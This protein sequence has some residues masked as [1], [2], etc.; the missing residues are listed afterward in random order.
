MARDCLC[1]RQHYGYILCVRWPRKQGISA[2][3]TVKSPVRITASRPRPILPAPEVFILKGNHKSDPGT[4][5]SKAMRECHT[6]TLSDNPSSTVTYLMSTRLS[7]HYI[8]NDR[9]AMA[10]RSIK[11]SELIWLSNPIYTD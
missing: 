3:I 9:S 6:Q 5:E 7:D 1:E 10:C 4:E 8:L 11:N 2:S